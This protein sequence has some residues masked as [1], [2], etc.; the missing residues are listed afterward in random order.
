[1]TNSKQKVRVG[2]DRLALRG[3]FV[4]ATGVGLL[5]LARAGRAL[6]PVASQRALETIQM[7]DSNQVRALLDRVSGLD[8][9]ICHLLGRS[10]GNRWGSWYGSV[11]IDPQSAATSEP[12]LTWLDNADIEAR[13]VPALRTALS[14]ADACVR[15]TAAQLIG[16]ARVPDLTPLLR[17]ELNSGN[18]GTREA[19]LIALG[20][21]D[22]PSSYEPARD[23]LRDVDVS[24]RVAAAWA[25]GQLERRE[26]VDAL[27]DVARDPDVR[28]RRTVAWALG[29]IEN[30]SA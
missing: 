1:M 16:R 6:N 21:F 14:H 3:M 7:Q 17:G 25:L 8:P 20:H 26:A 29:A 30:P 28:I 15:R 12:L 24:V 5:L 13:H 10:L 11:L 4:L 18:R 9:T 27:S 22:K 23:G 19:A 2:A